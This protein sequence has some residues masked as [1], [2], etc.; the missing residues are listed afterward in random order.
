MNENLIN[1]Q[2]ID[3]IPSVDDF[4]DSEQ[5]NEAGM[6]PI[7][8]LPKVARDIIK[9]YT[10]SLQCPQDYLTASVFAA[11]SLAMGRHYCIT[12]GC[13]VE[14]GNLYVALVG[15]AGAGKSKPISKIFIP[16][17]EIEKQS[18]AKYEEQ[19]AEEQAKP[20][21]QRKKVNAIEFIL[22]NSTPE[23]T[24]EALKYN[25]KGVYQYS[26][27]LSSFLS[28]RGMY[29]GNFD[30]GELN[31]LYDGICSV[32]RSRKTD[33]VSYSPNS[34]Y[35]IIGSIQ[36][37]VIIRKFSQDDLVNGFLFRFL[38]VFPDDLRKKYKEIHPYL[39][40]NAPNNWSYFI[41]K[42]HERYYSGRNDN[43]ITLIFNPD[44]LKLAAEF[45]NKYAVDMYN[46]SQSSSE[47]SIYAKTTQQLYKL[48]L[49]IAVSN[50]HKTIKRCDVE[51]AIRCM[52]YFIRCALKVQSLFFDKSETKRMSNQEVL[53]LFC[54]R[55]GI[56]GKNYNDAYGNEVKVVDSLAKA[57]NKSTEAIRKMIDRC[58]FQKMRE[59]QD[60]KY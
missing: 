57:M 38:F 17:E 10:K 1:S 7:D 18:M 52:A 29:N 3:E 4:C 42:I 5:E 21:D 45:H 23:A 60:D 14:Y 48:S 13:F 26:D 55:F 40:E 33:G 35:G 8:G 19:L 43:G 56:N 30:S 58:G 47:K 9:Y 36:P 34:Y 2:P 12:D 39:N 37:Q 22:R 51:Y 20:V 32:K 28:G 50:D 49:I 15:E 16:I 31:T 44:A 11:I 59:V 27:E 6:L 41:R 53:K 46:S 24:T 54:Q 25:P